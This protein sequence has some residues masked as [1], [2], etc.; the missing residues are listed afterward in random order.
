MPHELEAIDAM[1]GNL[2][3]SATGAAYDYG[4]D[5]DEVLQNILEISKAESLV[6]SCTSPS[7]YYLSC[8]VGVKLLLAS[9][10]N[11]AQLNY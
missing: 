4:S 2:A 10:V 11:D 9:G 7:L 3:D 8:G 5:N 1:W 6:S